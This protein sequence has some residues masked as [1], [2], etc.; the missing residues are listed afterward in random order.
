MLVLRL[1]LLLKLLTELLRLQLMTSLG[2]TRTMLLLEIEF[3][4]LD[5]CSPCLMCIFFLDVPFVLGLYFEQSASILHMHMWGSSFLCWAIA[6]SYDLHCPWGNLYRF[7]LLGILYIRSSYDL[8]SSLENLHH[9]DI[10]INYW[11]IVMI[12]IWFTFPLREFVP[13]FY[14]HMVCVLAGFLPWWLFLCFVPLWGRL[15]FRLSGLCMP[16]K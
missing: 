16:R 14:C 12:V 2:S 6:S 15:S 3:P 1:W 5:V 13:F 9:L 7:Y 8:H 10:C 4:L 11:R